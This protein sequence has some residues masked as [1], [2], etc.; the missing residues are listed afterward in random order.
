MA[1]TD[2]S[3][4]LKAISYEDTKPA[5][6]PIPI[7]VVPPPI[8]RDGASAG[9][10]PKTSPE[11]YLRPDK[12]QSRLYNDLRRDSGMATSSSTARDSRTTIATD[13]ESLKKSPS[14]PRI[15]LEDEFAPAPPKKT[16]KW[17]GFKAKKADPKVEHPPTIGQ[18][19]LGIT[20]DIPTGSFEDLTL[21]GRVDF[22]HR[23]SML[24]GG[25]K[26]TGVANGHARLKSGRRQ[27]SI[28][29]LAALPDSGGRVLSADDVLLSQRVRSMYEAGCAVEHDSMSQRLVS[30]VPG[31]NGEEAATQ[32]GTGITIS[33]AQGSPDTSK[34]SY[35][36]DHATPGSVTVDSGRESA[37]R[38]EENELAGGIEDWEDVQGGDVDR[39]GFIVPRRLPSQGSSMQSGQPHSPD[40]PRIQRVSTLLLLASETPRRKRSTLRRT[41]SHTG[42][43]RSATVPA[44]TRRLSGRSVRPSSSQNSYQGSLGGSSSRFRQ[45]ANRL[46]HNKDRRWMDEAGD[47]LTLPPGLANIA[48]HEEGGRAAEELK[49]KEWEREEK[50]RKMAKVVKTS[51][52]G[53]GMVFEFDTKSPKLIERTWKGIPDRWRATAW[54]A[55]LTSSARRRGGLSSDAELTS[56]FHEL[57]MQSSPDD[58]QIDIDVPRTINSHIMFRRRYR[59]G[60]RLLFRVLHALSLYFPETG[61]VQGMASLVATLLC[62][63]EE[64][65]AF[66]MMVR[67]WQLRGLERLYQSGFEGLMEALDEFEK[68][69]L[70]GNDVAT[71]LVSPSKIETSDSQ[72]VAWSVAAR[73]LS[74]SLPRDSFCRAQSY[75]PPLSPPLTPRPHR[76]T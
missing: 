69:W 73:S 71:R 28:S 51:K 50:W 54:H 17:S 21:P 67:L 46:P 14:L 35:S 72:R 52:N 33:R 59:G 8:S 3:D 27:P 63:Y 55:F 61:Y 9:S 29:M 31:Q 22:S 19:F 15:T 58:V 65:T 38:R 13:A 48:E 62:Y 75:S 34:S 64:E 74:L 24:I 36:S 41:P 47:M 45:A 30:S 70:A 39:Y 53:G 18:P 1:L 12:G 26:A 16:R 68:K 66:V 10:R 23:G 56:A 32:N 7:T 2:S 57:L 37:T 44:P 76:R 6:P 43:A 40:P 60:Q 25:K 4:Y 49:R 11:P 20:T 5:R 42:T